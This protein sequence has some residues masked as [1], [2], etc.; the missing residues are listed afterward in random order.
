MDAHEL[1]ELADRLEELE[2]L[3]L[4]VQEALM[5]AEEVESKMNDLNLLAPGH[6]TMELDEALGEIDEAMQGIRGITQR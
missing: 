3:Q 1:R 4:V 6:A 5:L 2:A